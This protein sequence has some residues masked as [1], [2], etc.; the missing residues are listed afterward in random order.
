MK[1][2]KK[3]EQN[4]KVLYI[5]FIFSSKPI[6]FLRLVAWFP[7]SHPVCSR[8]L[9]QFFLLLVRETSKALK[10]IYQVLKNIYSFYSSGIKEEVGDTWAQVPSISNRHSTDINGKSHIQYFMEIFAS[11]LFFQVILIGLLA[12][13]YIHNTSVFVNFICLNIVK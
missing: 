2:K 9:H 4:G 12:K 5:Q 10:K 11:I 13:A 3:W 7:L 1:N 6:F 8:P